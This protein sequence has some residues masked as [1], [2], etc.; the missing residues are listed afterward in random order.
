MTVPTQA[1]IHTFEEYLDQTGPYPF[2]NHVEDSCIFD[3]QPH[4]SVSYTV[5]Q[6]KPQETTV[7]YTLNN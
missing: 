1:A 4:Q 3:H 6:G 7:T 2:I 5:H